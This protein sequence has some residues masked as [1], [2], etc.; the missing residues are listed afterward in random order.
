MHADNLSTL[1][2]LLDHAHSDNLVFPTA[3]NTALRLQQALGDP[4]CHTAD[5]HRL[6]LSEPALSARVVSL[7]NSVMYAHGHVQ[8]VTSV[9]AAAERIGQRNLL[10]LATAAV[11]Q[12][13][14]AGIRDAALRAKA[15][16]LWSHSVHVAALAY[17]IAGSVTHTDADTASAKIDI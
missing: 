10:S 11:I 15:A 12:Q 16:Q 14:N 5:I 7:A 9:R 2:Q 6:L 1:A 8:T 3:V 4:D 13:L 17:E